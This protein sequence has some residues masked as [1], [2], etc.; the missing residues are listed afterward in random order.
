MNETLSSPT[1][2][3]PGKPK[4]GLLSNK[5]PRAALFLATYILVILIFQTWS[6]LGPFRIPW[7][8]LFVMFVLLPEALMS[9]FVSGGFA[10]LLGSILYLGV[11]ISGILTTSQRAFYVLYIAFLVLLALSVLSIIVGAFMAAS[12]K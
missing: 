11:A 12:P 7:L 9:S 4:T 8:F 3:P 6:S 10:I 1:P 2:V 5:G